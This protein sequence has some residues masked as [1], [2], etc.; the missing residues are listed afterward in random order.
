MYTLAKHGSFFKSNATASILIS[1]LI[2]HCGQILSA[3]SSTD[4]TRCPVLRHSA[5]FP[6]NTEQQSLN[7][8]YLSGRAEEVCLFCWVESGDSLDGC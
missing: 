6:L 3:E 4:V 5:R 2:S 7:N 8:P 1:L